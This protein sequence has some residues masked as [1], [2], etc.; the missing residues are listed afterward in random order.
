MNTK[1]AQSTYEAAHCLYAGRM[2]DIGQGI[3][4][5]DFRDPQS[6]ELYEMSEK[7]SFDVDYEWQFNLAEK[8]LIEKKGIIND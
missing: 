8:L 5:G 7:E 2:E 4:M 3:W 1:T 6:I